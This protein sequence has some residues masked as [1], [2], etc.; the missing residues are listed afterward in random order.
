MSRNYEGS[1]PKGVRLMRGVEVRDPAELPQP[2]VDLLGR[3]R[4]DALGPEALD[5]ERGEHG[6][7]GHRLA[8]DRGIQDRLPG[9]TT[10]VQVAEESACECVARP[11]R[12]ADVL[13]HEPG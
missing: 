4:L 10:A 13:E 11:G 1:D 2:L 9:R 7:V 3:Q 6:S 8:Q 12:I 5:V